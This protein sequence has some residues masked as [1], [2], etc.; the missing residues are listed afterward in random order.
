M[1]SKDVNVILLD[2]IMPEMDGFQLLG[3]L[4]QSEALSRIPVLV[5]TGK[6]LTAE[7][8]QLLKREANAFFQKGLN[9]QQDLLAQIKNVTSTCEVTVS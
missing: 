3:H 8:K 5:L 1:L 4:R 6:D 7:E 9:W 2:L